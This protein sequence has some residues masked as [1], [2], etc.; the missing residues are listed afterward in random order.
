MKVLKDDNCVQLVWEADSHGSCDIDLLLT[1]KMSGGREMNRTVPVMSQSYRYCYYHQD[2][3][4]LSEVTYQ[5]FVYI[6]ESD[7]TRRKTGESVVDVFKRDTTLPNFIRKHCCVK[8]YF[9]WSYFFI[10][11]I[12]SCIEFWL[13]VLFSSRQKTLKRRTYNVVLTSCAGWAVVLN[14][15]CGCNKC[16]YLFKKKNIFVSNSW[17][18][19]PKPQ[20]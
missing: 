3:R 17:T 2:V 15:L 14:T 20:T 10:T 5:S 6:R 18:S 12:L 19:F 11:F 4:N 13:V 9:R 1:F 7:G 8:F 16:V